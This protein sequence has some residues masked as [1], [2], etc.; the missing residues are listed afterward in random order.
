MN[1]PIPFSRDYAR[2][3]TEEA[4]VIPEML[5]L[6]Q[7]LLA[8][9]THDDPG[10]ESLWGFYG[11]STA[12]RATAIH[13]RLQDLDARRIGDMDATGIDVAILA[14]TAPGVQ[15][16]DAATARSLSVQVNDVLAA[17]IRRHPT[18]YVG[19]AACAPQDPA[20]A[21]QEIE[22]GVTR[23]GLRGVIINSHTR[24]EYLN[25]PKF[26][27]IFE[28]AESLDVP[29]Y[30]HP[31]TPSKGMV[32]PFIERGLDGA[33]YGFGVETGMHALT[34][35]TSG[36]FDRFPKLKL[37]L[38]HLGEALPF[39]MY[40]LDYMHLAGVRA[41]RYACMRP[42]QLQVSEYLK[43]NVWVTTSGMPWSPAIRFCQ[44]VLG[45]ERVLYAMDYPYQ[46]EP[47]EVRFSD[48]V[49]MSAATRRRF[50]QTNAEELFGFRVQP[51]GA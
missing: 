16:F 23:L 45:E 4:F 48:A 14:L 5:R 39:W 19:L 46:Y 38:G 21:A 12:P 36:V 35:I 9:G 25:D 17:A 47:D 18:R 41:R 40:R 15:V 37:V 2:V 32:Q 22:R 51:R 6:Y 24:H 42:L 10:F 50:F 3:A 27:T 26:W 13:E 31:T 28:A 44:E 34:I 11:G 8:S 20:H 30:L 29:V 33:I 49:P 43:R 1:T 7:E